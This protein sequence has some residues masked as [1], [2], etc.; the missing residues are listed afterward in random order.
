MGSRRRGNDGCVGIGLLVADYV[1][2]ELLG[3]GYSVVA[4]EAFV[5]VLHY[6]VEELDDGEAVGSLG[7]DEPGHEVFIY[8]RE[9]SDQVVR[10]GARGVLP[11]R[12]FSVGAGVGRVGASTGGVPAGDATVPGDEPGGGL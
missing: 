1:Y 4:L 5:P 11:A 12:R 6:V 8:R 2:Y 3:G 10:E 9:H 7:A